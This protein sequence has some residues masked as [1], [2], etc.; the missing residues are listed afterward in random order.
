MVS[1]CGRFLLIY[2]GEIYSHAEIKNDLSK[3]GRM[4]RGQSDTE[5]IVEAFSKWGII[6]TIGRMN[7]MFALAVFDKKDNRLTLVRDRLGI[8]PLYW[9]RANGY[10]I[11]SSE[12]KSFHQFR[13]WKPEL[14]RNSIASYMRHNYIG[15]PQTIYKDIFKLEPGSILEVTTGTEPRT[16]KYWDL[17]D[18][19]QA[20][21]NSR[22]IN[23]AD[24]IL[25]IEDLMSD[26]VNRRLV[27]DVP[28]GSLLSGGIDSSLVTALMTENSR[29][30]I[31]T[32]SVGFSS[33]GFN[34]APFAK[35]IS[36]HLDTDHTEI[37]A[38]PTD[39]LNLVESLPEMYDEPFSDSSQI[40]TA[41]ICAL[42]REHVSVV[43]SGDGGDELFGG[44][45]RYL[46]G[47]KLEKNMK[48][49]PRIGKQLVA[50]L[51]N[52]L[53][54]NLLNR[55]GHSA[56]GRFKINQLGHKVKKL[57]AVAAS[58]DPDEMYRS[59][60]THWD[61]P[62]NVVINS[63]EYKGE[64]WDPAL[65]T[66][67]PDF[68]D[69]MQILD[70]LTYLPD[71]IL[72]KVDRAS[73]AV[74]LEARIP[75][76]DYRLVEAS[77]ALPRE[78]KIRNGVSKW[79]MRQILYRRVPQHLIDRPKM[80]FG[81]PLAEW[82]RGPLREWAEALLDENMLRQ[83]GIFDVFEVRGHWTRHLSGENW[84]YL[85][86]DVLMFQSWITHQNNKYKWKPA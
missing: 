44:Y 55:L 67:F 26:S 1:S 82:L 52:K 50:I 51:L 24:A 28:I 22:K 80:G 7:G 58:S 56:P 86:W 54:E 49:F 70:S 46:V 75:L 16:K 63:N 83:Q 2:N 10:L 35:E 53:P 33:Q 71:D 13:T 32:F 38:N 8:K 3:I 6:S 47:N 45:N 72:T 65:K 84:A 79:I 12:L 15:A 69:R 85:I 64:V 17:K 34:E 43:L 30:K 77:W 31:K 59:M 48:R 25:E 60:L 62:S 61:T 4:V 40:P 5:V 57:A 41:L 14:D 23:A 18:V 37:Y 74:G 11:F 66:R 9:G 36:D 39:A 21:M 29:G 27:S 78:M 19:A 20:K 81:V 73:M 42:T 76:L 68:L